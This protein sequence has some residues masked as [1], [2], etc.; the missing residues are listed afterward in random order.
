[1]PSFYSALLFVFVFAASASDRYHSSALIRVVAYLLRIVGHILS[2][3]CLMY[4]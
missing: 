1:M 3:H 4:I 2:I